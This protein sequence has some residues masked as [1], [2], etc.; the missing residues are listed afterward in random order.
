MSAKSEA[1]NEA[2]SSS[3]ATT[4]RREALL[5]LAER[6]EK[7]GPSQELDRLIAP[8]IGWHRVKPRY[9]R[10]RHG[11]WISPQDF[12]GTNSD[13]SPI[14]DSLHGT[15]MWRDPPR[16]TSSVDAALTLVPEGA[17]I[18]LGKYWISRGEAW[19][20]IIHTDGVPDDPA[21]AF[22]AED[23]QTPAL[24]LCAAA[25]RALAETEGQ[26]SGPADNSAPQISSQ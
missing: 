2:G 25:L 5:A 12:G 26:T 24:A 11:A 21:R 3:V 10:G 17:G 18:N 6:C 13:G 14:L 9:T 22:E 15:E 4:S 19:S 1:L 8:M 23:A 20:A 16:F 7:E